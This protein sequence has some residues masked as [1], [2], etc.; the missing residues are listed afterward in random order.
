MDDHSKILGGN[1]RF[2]NGRYVAIRYEHQEFPKWVDGRL[3]ASVDEMPAQEEKPEAVPLPAIR[4]G[5]G[6]PRKGE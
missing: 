3:I 5:P 4:R 2:E 1:H 6:R